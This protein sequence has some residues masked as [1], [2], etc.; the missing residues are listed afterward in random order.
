MG[1][2]QSQ[3]MVRAKRMVL[4]GMSAYAAAKAVGITRHAIYMS[5]WYREWRDEKK[6]L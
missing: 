5:A 2:K 3:E 4:G 6:K 1:A